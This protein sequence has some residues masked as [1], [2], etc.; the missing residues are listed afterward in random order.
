MN[1]GKVIMN[2]Y[3]LWKQIISRPAPFLIAEIGV[4]HENDMQTARNM[5]N[6]A[7][8]AGA[9]AVKFQTYKAEKL[10]VKDSPA[11]W[12][13]AKEKTDTQYQLFKKYDK[14][15]EKEFLLQD[16]VSRYLQHSFYSLYSS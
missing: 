13:R 14:F 15:G 2:N 3:K 8:K 9:D 6:E 11:Y 7:K 10:A 1:L 4:N 12:D 5:I 16:C